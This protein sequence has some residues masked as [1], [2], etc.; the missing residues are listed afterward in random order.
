MALALTLTATALTLTAT[1]ALS[2]QKGEIAP[3]VGYQFGTT[4]HVRNGDLKIGSDVNYGV[5]ADMYVRRNSAVELAW[6]HQPTTLRFV[7]VVGV[8][9][10]IGLAVNYFQIGGLTEFPQGPA[11][12]FLSFSLGAT[13]YKPESKPLNGLNLSDEW[14]FSM[15]LGG[16]VK[17]MASPRVGLRLQGHLMGTFLDSGGG[18]FCGFGG[19]SLGFFGSGI[20]Q[21]DVSAGLAIAF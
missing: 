19:C 20:L 21:G 2:Q 5:T 4:I 14:R 3:F 1:P 16:G 12:P 9:E 6:F 11:R 7:P 17:Y 13:Y 10:S 8:S 18:L 15:I